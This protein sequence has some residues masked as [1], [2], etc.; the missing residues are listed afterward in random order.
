M[1]NAHGVRLLTLRLWRRGN[2]NLLC[3]YVPP[4]CFQSASLSSTTTVT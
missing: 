3:Y 2:D 4:S 1:E